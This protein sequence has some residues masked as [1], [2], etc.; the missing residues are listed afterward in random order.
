M[1]AVFESAHE[2]GRAR[3]RRFRS[4]PSRSPDKATVI[5]EV[6]IGHFL[7]LCDNTGML[8]HAVHS[9]ADRA[10]GYCVDD[11]AR[12][13]LL[14]SAL[15]NSG[16]AELLSEI[17]TTRFAAFIQHAWNPDTRPFPQFHELRSPMA[18]RVGLGRQS[19]PN[20]LGFGRMRT[21]GHRSVSPH[22]GPRRCSRP[23]FRLSRR[24]RRRA[25]GPSRFWVWTPI[26][27]WRPETFSPAACASYWP[28]G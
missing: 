2:R 13:L 8:Q 28:T 1:L 6:R 22:A 15:A 17:D 3:I 19:W 25:P 18:G 21:H 24:S 14:S 26:A 10:H 4:S 23:R 11:N 7:S 16:E 9:V 20:A 27:R 12:A 5:P